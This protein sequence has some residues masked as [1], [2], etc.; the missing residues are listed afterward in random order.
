MSL[1]LP[2]IVRPKPL[3]MAILLAPRNTQ[4]WAKNSGSS[5]SATPCPPSCYTR[6]RTLSFSSLSS[7]SSIKFTGPPDKD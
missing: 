5:D 4:A 1:A 7:F 2:M 6:S 3:A